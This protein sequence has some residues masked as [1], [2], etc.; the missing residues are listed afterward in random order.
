MSKSTSARPTASVVR[1]WALENGLPVQPVGTKGRIPAAT[2][3]A[4]NKGRRGG[5]RYVGNPKRT[6][7]VPTTN[8]I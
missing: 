6:V 7:T 5:Q 8:P 3:E 2:I 4:F 1:E